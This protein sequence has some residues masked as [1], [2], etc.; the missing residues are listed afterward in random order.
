M[1][2]LGDDREKK[3]PVERTAGEKKGDI[4]LQRV[5]GDI[6]LRLAAIQVSI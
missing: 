2:F 4:K 1:V 3:R 5:E 6:W